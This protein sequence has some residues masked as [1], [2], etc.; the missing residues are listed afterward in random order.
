MDVSEPVKLNTPS[1]LNA[2]L[3][4]V[5]STYYF[6]KQQFSGLKLNLKNLNPKPLSQIIVRTRIWVDGEAAPLTRFLTMTIDPKS[7]AIAQNQ[8]IEVSDSSEAST[9]KP[10]RHVEIAA[11]ATAYR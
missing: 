7:S 1:F 2:N 9:F 3:E 8:T 5:S 4:V 11:Y 6:S 10:I